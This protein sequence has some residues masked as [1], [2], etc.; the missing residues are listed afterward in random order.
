MKRI[1]L[2]TVLL[3]AAMSSQ[4]EATKTSIRFRTIGTG[5][6]PVV[7]DQ[8]YAAY[9]IDSDTVRVIDPLT[10]GRLDVDQPPDCDLAALGGGQVM[11]NCSK[12]LAT[13]RLL[14]IETGI[15]REPR[16]DP[17]TDT[18]RTF[19]RIGSR[20]I[21]GSATGDGYTNNSF[22]V[23]WHTGERRATSAVGAS[24]YPD[25]SRAALALRL[26]SPLRRPRSGNYDPDTPNL[27][28]D[29]F[30]PYQYERPYGLRS[31]FDGNTFRLE[32]DSCGKRVPL[33]IARGPYASEQLLAGKITYAR[34]SWL[35]AVLPRSGRRFRWAVHDIYRAGNPLADVHHTADRIFAS[36][37]SMSG[38][39]WRI[40]VAFWP[41]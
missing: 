38:P 15:V 23:N 20:W 5:I 14:D 29:P 25:L 33:A 26:C 13:V 35:Y 10:G 3:I 16:I 12:P 9:P 30:D 32:V 27:F 4:A 8:R 24:S 28:G 37:P 22:Y 19:E 40:A 11:W 34:A 31:F 21:A 2:C 18:S 39:Q 17:A 41:R 7:T 1:A 6:G 36:V